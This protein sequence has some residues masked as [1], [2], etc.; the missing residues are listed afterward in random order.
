MHSRARPERPH[1]TRAQC[2]YI[3]KIRHTCSAR[4]HIHSEYNPWLAKQRLSHKAG[5]R[6]PPIH[7]GSPSFSEPCPFLCL[8]LCAFITT[9]PLVS[10]HFDPPAV[11]IRGTILQVLPGEVG[12]DDMGASLLL[13]G[14]VFAGLAAMGSG[15]D[16][17]LNGSIQRPPDLV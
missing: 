3:P 4:P 17:G 11:V 15:W 6:Q 5:P 16:G 1:L 2:K 9:F 8:F 14:S 7:K 10:P 13:R 12:T